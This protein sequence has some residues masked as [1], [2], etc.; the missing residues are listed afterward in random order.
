M[1]STAKALTSLLTALTLT[2]LCLAQDKRSR[3]KRYLFK[4]ASRVTV[5]LPVGDMRGEGLYRHAS[6]EWRALPKAQ[7]RDGKLTF[8]LSPEELDAGST[9][10]LIDKPEWLDANDS[11]PPEVT[12]ALIDGKAVPCSN[13]IKLGWLDRAPERFELHVA[14][15]KNPLDPSSVRAVVNG[16]EVRPDGKALRFDVDPASD[17]KGRILCSIPDLAHVLSDGTTRI[18]V[19]CDDLAADSAKRAVE[20]AFIVTRPPAIKLDK[21]T[22]LAPNGVKIF[23]DSIFQGYDNVECILDG[24]LQTPGTTTYK[25][26]WASAETEDDHW[27]CFVLPK[28]RKLSGIEITWAHWKNT[29]WTSSRFDIMTWDGKA[30]QRAVR[31]QKNPEERTTTHTFAPRTTDR[32]LAWQPSSGG[33]AGMPNIF[34]LSE[35]VF[36]P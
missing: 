24:K 9:V 28:P 15:A 16:V 3:G 5:S 32:V 23:V 19:E 1:P 20:L 10:L 18:V 36:L 7:Y 27:M 14:D 35:V 8:T 26:T 13:E 22:K 12:K 31:V 33:H 6:G 25:V 2:S 11:D 17:R 30:W 21:P 29:Y 4:T 34:W